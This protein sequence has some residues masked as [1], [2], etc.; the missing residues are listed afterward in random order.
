[1]KI[2][3]FFADIRDVIRDILHLI[4]TIISVATH[5]IIFWQLSYPW[6]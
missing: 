1:M 6:W 5:F 4:T 3:I 2:Q